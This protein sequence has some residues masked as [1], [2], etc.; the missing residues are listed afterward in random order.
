M[1]VSRCNLFKQN[2][3][4]V[5]Q[6][7]A[8]DLPAVTKIKIPKRT[9]ASLIIRP[10]R[11]RMIGVYI[12]ILTI[13][14]SVGL[15]IRFL[16]SH[17]SVTLDWLQSDALPLAAIIIGGSVFI[18]FLEYSRWT[19][20]VENG[21]SVEGPAGAFGERMTLSLK[22]IDWVKTHRSLDSW[23][24]FGNGIYSTPRRRILVSP[25]FFKPAE[26]REFLSAIGY[27]RIKNQ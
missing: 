20:R 24:Q 15:A 9:G 21:D 4:I 19:L 2:A 17:E 11:L 18:S 14:I 10:S 23:L 26:F 16:L 13:A 22:E 7:I 6:P 27:D 1:R 12:I 8:K 3:D 5:S 25:C